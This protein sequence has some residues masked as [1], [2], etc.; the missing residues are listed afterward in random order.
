VDEVPRER[1]NS[2]YFA[3][4]PGVFLFLNF[5]EKGKDPIYEI[6]F[7]GKPGGEWV[8]VGAPENIQALLGQQLCF[9]TEPNLLS[10]PVYDIDLLNFERKSSRNGE[11][12]EILNIPHGYKLISHQLPFGYLIFRKGSPVDM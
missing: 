10:G 12:K 5:C 7:S 11:S 2:K 9:K 4:L 1:L 8:T 3:I 6:E